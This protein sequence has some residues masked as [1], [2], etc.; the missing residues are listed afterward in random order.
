VSFFAKF[1]SLIQL[2]SGNV[3]GAIETTTASQAEGVK[4]VKEETDKLAASLEN[5]AAGLLSQAEELGKTFKITSNTDFEKEQEK[6]RKEAAEK[7]KKAL[8]DRLNNDINLR[9]RNLA[10]AKALLLEEQNE[11]IRSNQV[12]IDNEK[13]SFSNR[14]AALENISQAKK[15]IAAIELAEAI[16]AEQEVRDGKIIEIKKTQSEIEAATLVYNNKLK[17]INDDLLKAQTDAQKQNTENLKAEYARQQEEKLKAIDKE[18]QAIADKNK[19]EYNKQIQALNKSFEEGT[20]S[21]KEYADKREQ[22]EKTYQVATL[23]NE[24]EHQKKLL[25]AAD[26]TT[27]EKAEAL[28]RLS[29]LEKDLS[30][31]SVQITKDNEEKKREEILKTLDKVKEGSEKAFEFIGGILNANSTAQKNRIAEEQAAAEKKAARD[32][33]IAESSGL[34]EEEKAA[35]IANINARLDAQKRQF[36]ER[37]RQIN[38]QNARFEKIK[39]IFEITLATAKAIA[40]AGGNPFKI[41]L[42]AATGAAQLAIALATPLPKYYKGKNVT[43]TDKYEG[44]ATVNEYRDEVIKRADGT[45]EF[46]KGRNVTTWIGSN[47]QVFPS[48]DAYLESLLAATHLNAK[49]FLSGPPAVTVNVQVP[50]EDKKTHDLLQKLLSKPTANIAIYDNGHAKYEIENSNW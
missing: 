41:A 12:I 6:Q 10:A 28:R 8:E 47:D 50:K 19:D 9:K 49:P 38:L 22:I 48:L 15:N 32:I 40:E 2:R 20:I 7:A 18:F 13:T 27:D 16:R 14:L 11:S 35:R 39:T 29:D 17:A 3:K 45:T 25:Q 24:I 21:Q 42:A 43:N 36:A 30:D 37:E 34:A 44:L 46:P 23:I 4:D 1:K 26:I 33:E 31:L 5:L